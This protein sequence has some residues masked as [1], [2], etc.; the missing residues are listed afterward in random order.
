[1]SSSLPAACW[2]IHDG[3]AGNRRQA[4]A[5]AEALALPFTEVV[6]R[7]RRLARW[8]APRLPGPAALA[9]GDDFA[10]ALRQAPPAVAIGCGRLAALATRYAGR[11][12]ARTVQI[13]DP[14]IPTHHWDVVVAPAHDHLAGAN[15]ITLLGSLNPVDERWLAQARTRFA[16]LSALP[17]PRTALLLGGPTRNA[18][19]ELRDLQQL[20]DTLAAERAREGGSVVICGSRRTPA[21]WAAPVR[22]R[23]GAGHGLCWLDDADGENPYAGVLAWAQRIVV[24]PDSTNLL[25]EACATSAPVYVLAADKARGR[26]RDFIE[27]LRARGRVERFDGA[28]HGAPS[29]TPSCA[30]L[31]E[32]ARVAALVRARLSPG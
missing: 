10:Q 18:G 17:A 24:T 26:A 14:R 2:V 30:P 13:L 20:L 4:T 28:I 22:E 7:P 29:G 5:L 19:F 27:A 9:F 21:D 25:S 3:A 1:M 6:L 16:D 8:L 31:R 15:V 11:A 23:V 32:T 12:G